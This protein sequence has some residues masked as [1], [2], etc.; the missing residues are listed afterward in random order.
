MRKR[1]EM[2]QEIANKS[3]KITWFMT[4]I[5]LF[6][7]GIIQQFDS[8]QDTNGYLMIANLSVVLYI[9]LERFYFSKVTDNKSFITFFAKV[10]I[11][12]LI[13]VSAMI[14]LIR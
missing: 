5:A 2:E 3:V 14:W 4:V 8:N 6:I 13:I 12:V 11:I 7:L 9:F 1:D 10:I